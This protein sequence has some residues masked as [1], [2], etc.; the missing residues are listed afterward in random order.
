MVR[1]VLVDEAHDGADASAGAASAPAG[2]AVEGAFD[3]LHVDTRGIMTHPVEWL[4]AGFGRTNGQLDE[5]RRRAQV[6]L[7]FVGVADAAA[8]G[9]TSRSIS[10][11]EQDQCPYGSPS[12]PSVWL[13]SP[14]PWQGSAP[15]SLSKQQITGSGGQDRLDVEVRPHAR[16]GPVA[17]IITD[18][19]AG[20]R[21]PAA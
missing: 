4:H 5:G 20:L 21:R 11:Q 19:R 3:Q 14:A 12:L 13:R 9:S 17:R 2:G 1:D 6:Q 8:C 15:A 18:A 10:Q 16:S 7:A